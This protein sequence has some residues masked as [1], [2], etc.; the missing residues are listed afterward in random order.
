M[1]RKLGD[2]FDR[3]D[4][5]CQLGEHGGLVTAAGTDLE[6]AMVRLQGKLLGHVGH[7]VGLRDRLTLAYRQRTVRVCAARKRL[8]HEAMAGNLLQCIEHGTLLTIAYTRNNQQGV[9][10]M[11]QLIKVVAG[12]VINFAQASCIQKTE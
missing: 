10:A 8:R 9:A 11:A 6:H 5:G 2:D 7:D 1:R 12:I 3:V 4:V